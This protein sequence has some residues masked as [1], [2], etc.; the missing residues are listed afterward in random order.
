MKKS[1]K[2]VCLGDSL[3]QG[4][5]INTA[6]CWVTLLNNKLDNYEVINCGVSGDTTNGMLARFQAIIKEIQPDIVLIMGGTNDLSVNLSNKNIISNLLAIVRQAKFHKITP[7]LGVIPP[8]YY[9]D[10]SMSE[11]IFINHKKYANRI[12]KFQQKLISFAK[13]DNQIYID[14]SKNMTKDLFL[15][16]GIHPSEKGNI[17]MKNNALEVLKNY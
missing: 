14:F 12:I 16:D 3:T 5:D 1:K 11:S 4:Y 9:E 6:D 7:V 8:F 2:I 10:S 13:S 17:I 15:K